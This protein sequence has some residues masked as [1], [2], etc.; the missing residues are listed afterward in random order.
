MSIMIPLCLFLLFLQL[1]VAS[2]IM[3]TGVRKSHLG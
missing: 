1:E 3:Y 2:K